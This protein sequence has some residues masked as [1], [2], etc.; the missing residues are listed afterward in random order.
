MRTRTIKCENENNISVI[1]GEKSDSAFV[2]EDADG[3]YQMDTELSVSD[4]AMRMELSVW[5][6][7]KKQSHRKPSLFL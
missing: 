5:M 3:L 4:N 1:F 7:W 6:N 2:L